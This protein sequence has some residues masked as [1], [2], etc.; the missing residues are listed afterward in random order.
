MTHKR[1]SRILGDLR[2]QITDAFYKAM[3]E[4]PSSSDLNTKILNIKAKLPEKAPR[5][6][7]VNL[8]GFIQAFRTVLEREHLIFVF[9]DTDGTRYAVSTGWV[10]DHN[11]RS[12]DEFHSNGRGSYLCTLPGFFV[13]KNTGT[14]YFQSQEKP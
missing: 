11:Y 2:A 8:E 13:W 5:W 4:G 10:K 14:I 1:L 6:A 3:K 12:T 9:E 7:G